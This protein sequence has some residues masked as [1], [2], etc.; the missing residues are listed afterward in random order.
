MISIRLRHDY[1]FFNS[2]I[3]LQNQVAILRATI[4]TVLT[5][6]PQRFLLKQVLLSKNDYKKDEVGLQSQFHGRLSCYTY[7]L[8]LCCKNCVIFGSAD[9]ELASF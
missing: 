1:V 8:L 6:F 5:F 3:T 2:I 7:I 4:L 9:P